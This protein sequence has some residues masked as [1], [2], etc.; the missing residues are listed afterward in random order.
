MTFFLL[1][2]WGGGGGG[3]IY[4]SKKKERKEKKGSSGHFQADLAVLPLATGKHYL[5][6]RKTLLNGFQCL[7]LAVDP[8]LHSYMP[9]GGK[10]GKKRVESN[11][12]YILHWTNVLHFERDVAEQFANA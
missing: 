11:S 9:G 1:F 6:L 7:R 8:V 12:T 2:F 3:G 10:G 5:L 4:I